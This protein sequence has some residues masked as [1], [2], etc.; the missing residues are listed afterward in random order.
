MKLLSQTDATCLL[1]SQGIRHLVRKLPL[2]KFACSCGKAKCPHQA[3]ASQLHWPKRWR[4]NE[5][6]D[7]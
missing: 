3:T 4:R 5:E 1:E 2:D 7:D 6:T